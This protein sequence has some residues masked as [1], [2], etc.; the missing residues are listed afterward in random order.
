MKLHVVGTGSRGNGYILEDDRDALIIE[1][2]L[3]FREYQ[4]PLGYDTSKVRGVLISHHHGDHASHCAEFLDRYI[5]CYTTAGEAPLI[6]GERGRIKRIEYNKTITLGS[7]RVVAFPTI[8]DTP[9]PCGYVINHPDTGNILFL[10]DTS[11]DI[12]AL[13]RF[14][15]ISSALL[16]CN[17]DPTTIWDKATAGEIADVYARRAVESHLSVDGAKAVAGGLDRETLRQ[18]ILIHG[19]ESNGNSPKF[20]TELEEELGGGARVQIARRGLALDINKLPF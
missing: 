18:V 20:I 4:L 14:P 16:E 6:K 17:W 1:A 7:F 13:A 10:T 5:P 19:S 15:K 11:D 9:E 3:P 8:H 2:G 12:A